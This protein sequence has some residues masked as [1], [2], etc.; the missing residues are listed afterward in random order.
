MT[1]FK[2]IVTF[3]TT[4]QP[5]YDPPSE[6][7]SELLVNYFHRHDRRPMVIYRTG[8]AQIRSSSLESVR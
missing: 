4:S 1:V 7:A 3:L 5:K 2:A 8:T 6:F